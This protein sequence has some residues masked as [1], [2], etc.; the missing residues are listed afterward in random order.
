MSADAR[1]GARVLLPP[2]IEPA[3]AT[4]SCGVLLPPALCAQDASLAF[5]ALVDDRG[6]HLA[7]AVI[8]RGLRDLVCDVRDDVLE[9]DSGVFEREM[10]TAACDAWARG[11]DVALLNTCR[12]LHWWRGGA[13]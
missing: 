8:R 2:A 12:D 6:H 11:D 13:S 7:A 3:T 10:L 1:L 9:S 4:E 5:A